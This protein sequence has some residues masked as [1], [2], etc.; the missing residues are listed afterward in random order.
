[1]MDIQ[2]LIE[3]KLKSLELGSVGDIIHRGG[4]MFTTARCP[5]FKTEEGQQKAIEQ[6]KKWN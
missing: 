2:G 5:E 3:G 1:M 4:T 6:L